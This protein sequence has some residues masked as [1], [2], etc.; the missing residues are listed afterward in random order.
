MA[1]VTEE[2]RDIPGYD[3]Y[4][5]S[6]LG[7]VKNKK[8]NKLLAKFQTD[9]GYERL[10]LRQ[11][12]PDGTKKY[13]SEDVHRLVAKAF[14]LNPENKKTV[15]HKNRVKNDNRVEN[16]EWAT[17]SEQN[18][19]SRIEKYTDQYSH[20]SFKPEEDEEEIW[21]PTGNTTYHVS[22]KGK[23]KNIETNYMKTITVDG[24]GYCCVGMGTKKY[25]IHRLVAK[26]F[27]PNYSEDLVVNH[28]DGNKSN[29]HLLN[30]ECVS[31][32]RNILHAYESK[33]IK[34][35]K[36]IAVI[37]V[38]YNEN[39]VGSYS[40]LADAEAA[41]G[42]NR[43]SIHHA[44]NSESAS[45]GFKWY[46]T[47][48]DFEADRPNIKT[49]IFKVFQYGMNGELIAVFD[50]F[51]KAEEVTGVKKGNI[52]SAVNKF[53][54][55]LRAA[56]GFL[57]TT[58]QVPKTDLL[59][60]LK[61]DATVLNEHINS[62][63]TKVGITNRKLPP[64]MIIKILKTHHDQPTWT[65]KQIADSL[66]TTETRVGNVIRGVT[67]MLESE[68]PCEGVTWEEYNVLMGK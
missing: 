39:I 10:T 59:L 28:K 52:T 15:N 27:I 3:M 8:L 37:Q 46:R 63:R 68:F 58:S 4:Q 1:T 50:D 17:H 24:R 12:Q 20:A 60:Q 62:A 36:C 13:V 57:W 9:L 48:E 44:V 2:W 45:H 11:K 29:N 23:V 32:S 18:K 31:Q 49:D 42:I 34:K 64:D 22:N 26:A 61:Q 56:G 16:L 38:D 54:D 40:S 41:T 7:N 14:L 43:G 66:D 5:A 65:N 67:K 30:L 25:Y 33:E 19:H 35:T 55:R 53:K 51:V 21:K 6:N 47:M